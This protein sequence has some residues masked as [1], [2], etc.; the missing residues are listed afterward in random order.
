[1]HDEAI[2]HA[3]PIALTTKERGVSSFSWLAACRDSVRSA[4]CV[5]YLDS[6]G[7][8]LSRHLTVAMEFTDVDVAEIIFKE[9]LAK[10]DYC[11][12]FLV[13]IRGKTCV[14]KVVS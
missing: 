1:M 6:F 5:L 13:V 4:Y 9:R 7:F 10:R 11:V 12:I 3:C 14:M 8:L 2:D